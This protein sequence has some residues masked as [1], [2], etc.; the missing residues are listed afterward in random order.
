MLHAMRCRACLTMF[1]ARP[2]QGWQTRLMIC[3]YC[4]FHYAYKYPANTD[5]SVCILSNPSEY[6]SSTTRYEPGG[7]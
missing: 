2:K 3:P 1:I 6:P 5:R 4:G 7:R